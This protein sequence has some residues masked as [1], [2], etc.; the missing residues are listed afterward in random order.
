MIKKSF[1]ASL[2]VADTTLYEVPAGK[3]AE[4]VLLYATDV[5]G[6]TTDF[7]VDYYDASAAATLTL[8][9]EYSLSAKD[10]FTIGGQ[11][12]TFIMMHEGDKVIARCDGDN[13]VTML[14][15]VIEYN[16]I[17]QGG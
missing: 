8:F 16:D 17:I 15:S 9:D 3:K 4:W 11:V 14:I 10:F 13:D 1:G 7:S 6:S 12:N 5:S 2:L